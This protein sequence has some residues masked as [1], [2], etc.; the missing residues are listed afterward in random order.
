[1]RTTLVVTTPATS[2]Q[3]LP[4]EEMRVA[5]GLASD[6]ASKD[7]ILNA[8]GLAVAAA[9]MSECNI[10][11]GNGAEPTL[12]QETLTETFFH[13]HRKELILARRHNIEI[14]SS[15]LDDTTLADEEISVEPESGFLYRLWLQDGQQR[16]WDG[17]KLVVVYKAGFT[18]LPGDLVMA[19]TDFYRAASQENT[20]DPFVKSESVEIPG[21]QTKRRDFWVGSMPGGATEDA[22]PDIVAGQLKRYR[23]SAW[24]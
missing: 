17:R 16:S 13:V 21:L 11:I 4:I 5:A 18:E 24:G 23:N 15:T 9:I 19:V 12:W 1:M 20:R 14:V 8:R 10:A 2:L 6:D 22:V 3:L 7:A